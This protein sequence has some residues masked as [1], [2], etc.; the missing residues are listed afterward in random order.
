MSFR[1]ESRPSFRPRVTR[2]SML[3]GLGLGT[4]A[5]I[6]RPLMNECFAQ[7]GDGVPRRLL[8][9]YM[10][11]CSI[12]ANWLPTGGRIPGMNMGDA[13]QF[14]FKN[15]NETLAPARDQM[16]LVTGLDVKQI[17]GC[18]H[19]SSIIRIMTGGGIKPVGMTF[20][21]VMATRSPL[22]KGTQIGSLQLGT[23]T[24]ADNGSNGIQLRVMSYDGKSP[25]PPEIEP[26]KT[27]TRIFSSVVPA[28]SGGDQTAMIER[29]L[30]EERS[31]LDLVKDDLA[32]LSQRLPGPQREKLDSH[33]EGLREV[34][35]SLHGPVVGGN[36]GTLPG[37]PE[38][39]APNT[40]INH[41]KVLDQY[42]AITKLALQFDVTR[43]ITLMYASGN[44]QVSLG[45]FMPTYAKGPL[46]R[47]A[48]AYK[49]PAL[50]EAT[51]WYCGLTAKFINELGAIKEQD[52]SSLLDNTM[53]PFF[54]EVGQF[55][56]HNDVPFALFGGKKFGLQ[57]GRALR[58]P[59]RTP[60][61]IWVSVAK[62]FGVEMPT[63]GDAALNAGPL[64]ELFA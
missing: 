13:R 14:T 48:H 39:L 22:V 49:T 10:P 30:A 41:P 6:A 33:L 28:S 1:P 37:P 19:G 44:S 46:H 31:V 11:N 3:R 26:T 8:V 61:D 63:F 34:E 2:R 52:G 16:T 38:V 35:R 43:V 17:Q 50:I 7:A 9:L 20:D 56:E 59:G 55:H 60:N 51:R 47:L 42:F 45:D 64:P 40:S 29:T 4:A 62:L 23:D 5:V 21:Q 58:Y 54:S 27:Y 32:R 18:N 15:G 25:L 53:V 12:R 36:R 57:G 24:R